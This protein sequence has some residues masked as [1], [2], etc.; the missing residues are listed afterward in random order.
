VESVILSRQDNH[1]N[2]KA[3]GECQDTIGITPI[4]WMGN[5]IKAPELLEEL[6]FGD[7]RH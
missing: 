6:E 4:F 5:V 2:P 7:F 3:G 1:T